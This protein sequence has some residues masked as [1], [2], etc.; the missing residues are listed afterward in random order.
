[1][2]DDCEVFMLHFITFSL[3]DPDNHHYVGVVMGGGGGGGQE[4][5]SVHGAAQCHHPGMHAALGAGQSGR[6]NM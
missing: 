5:V 4:D 1:M 3:A 2:R 6:G